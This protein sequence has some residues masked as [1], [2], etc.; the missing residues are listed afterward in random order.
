MSVGAQGKAGLHVDLTRGWVSNAPEPGEEQNAVGVPTRR[1]AGPAPGNVRQGEV[2]ESL[3]R[4]SSTVL[5][6]LL[7]YQKMGRY[8]CIH[9]DVTHETGS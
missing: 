4:S 8:Y 1:P 5:M 6:K 2:A 7:G 9:S 3:S